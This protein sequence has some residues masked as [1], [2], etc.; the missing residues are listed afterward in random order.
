M[1]DRMAPPKTILC[2]PSY[3]L[4]ITDLASRA[5]RVDRCIAV[6]GDSIGTV[7]DM[8][9]APGRCG[10]S[11]LMLAQLLEDFLRRLGL[12]VVTELDPDAPML[13]KNSRLSTSNWQICRFSSQ[14]GTLSHHSL[15]N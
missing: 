14:S 11:R 12:K 9:F 2:T 3:A 5:Y 1:I 13:V 15:R 4:S 8:S 7:A 10:E 6:R